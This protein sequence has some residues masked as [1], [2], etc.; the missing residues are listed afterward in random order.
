MIELL[1][2]TA[3][4][5]KI[6]LSFV[7]VFEKFGKIILSHLASKHGLKGKEVLRGPVFELEKKNFKN[8][9][10]GSER[11]AKK[12]DLDELVRADRAISDQTQEMIDQP[13]KRISRVRMGMQPHWVILK[14]GKIISKTI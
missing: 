2:D 9:S 3:M 12:S 7:P 1:T 8:F 14:H 5:E 10:D 4:K 6:K 13:I 11:K